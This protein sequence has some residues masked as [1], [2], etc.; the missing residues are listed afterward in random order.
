LGEWWWVDPVGVAAGRGPDDRAV[1]VL[2]DAPPGVAL[3]PV[4][5]PALRAEVRR[6]GRALVGGGV[7]G[8]VVVEVAQVCGCPA[9]GVL[10]VLV[11]G[12]DVFG[13]VW[14]WSV[15]GGA[16][17]REGAAWRGR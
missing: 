3:E 10:A 4:V 9:A 15:V 12:D 17:V 6:G 5:R 13:Q 8:L 11:P 1:D 2:G 7:V 16:V 14:W